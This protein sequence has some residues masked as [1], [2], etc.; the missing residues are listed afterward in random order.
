MAGGGTGETGRR[1]SDTGLTV[2]PVGDAADALLGGIA[3]A[4]GIGA[5]TFNAAAERGGIG[6]GAAGEGGRRGGDGGVGGS[7]G[8]GGAANGGGLGGGDGL[9]DICC[10]SP[11]KYVVALLP[12]SKSVG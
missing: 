11:I 3:V 12:L 1:S 10:C 4:D 8:G 5:F 2:V 6:G 9:L 7:G